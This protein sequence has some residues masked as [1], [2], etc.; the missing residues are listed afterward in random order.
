MQVDDHRLAYIAR[1]IDD[2]DSSHFRKRDEPLR[3]TIERRPPGVTELTL[4]YDAPKSF[5]RVHRQKLAAACRL[6][7]GDARRLRSGK[8]RPR[9][10]RHEGRLSVDVAQRVGDAA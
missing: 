9:C 4:Y 3:R 1:S 8:L 6:P 7:T 2:A 5:L 10:R